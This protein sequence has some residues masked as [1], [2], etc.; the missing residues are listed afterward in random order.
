MLESLGDLLA[1]EAVSWLEECKNFSQDFDG[2][3]L[4]AGVSWGSDHD[5]G[6]L[7]LKSNYGETNK[8]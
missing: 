2:K 7:K 8:P 5:Y 1:G 3:T 4:Q 6:N